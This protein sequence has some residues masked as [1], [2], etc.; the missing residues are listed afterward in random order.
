MPIGQ[1]YPTR[2]DAARGT[3]PN[4]NGPSRA[5]NPCAGVE[6]A[7]VFSNTTPRRRKHVCFPNDESGQQ[8]PCRAPC[9]RRQRTVGDAR[10]QT[11]GHFR[12][13]PWGRGGI[14]VT[15]VKT[16]LFRTGTDF[17]QTS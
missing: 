14:R 7:C 3:S 15:L 6:A 5:V 12:G 4:R 13:F 9:G 1:D 8:P 10:S 11:P 2:P 16:T 17:T